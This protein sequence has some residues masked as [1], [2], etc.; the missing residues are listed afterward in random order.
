M[1]KYP[2]ARRE[3]TIHLVHEE[4]QQSPFGPAV[5]ILHVTNWIEANIVN[6]ASGGAHADFAALGLSYKEIEK[7]VTKVMK[8][9]RNTFDQEHAYISR[10]WRASLVE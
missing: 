9:H 4:S 2:Q 3:L 5:R 8:T 1:L 10:V 6:K 7:H